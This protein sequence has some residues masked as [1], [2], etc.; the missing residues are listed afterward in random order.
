MNKRPG[1]A[2]AHRHGSSRK[3][4]AR[5]LCAVLL[6]IAWNFLALGEIRS[7]GCGSEAGAAEAV[8]EAGTAPISPSVPP[9]A[10]SRRPITLRATGVSDSQIALAWTIPAGAARYRIYRD[11]APLGMTGRISEYDAKL[12]ADTRYCYRIA[13]LDGR[14]VEILQSN[15]ACATTLPAEPDGPQQ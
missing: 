9:G 2:A 1:I 7:G 13:A 11:G 4:S 3:N 5:L 6:L 15:E 10:Q 8:S 12:K 14:D